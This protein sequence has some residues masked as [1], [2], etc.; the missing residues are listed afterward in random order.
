LTHALQSAGTDL[1][2]RDQ[3]A[4]TGTVAHAAAAGSGSKEPTMQ[5]ARRFGRVLVIP[6][7]LALSLVGA[8]S[9]AAAEPNGAASRSAAVV[10][11]T[12]TL[13]A[14]GAGVARLG[15]TYVL[16]GAMKGGS[17]TIV[18]A[19]PATSVRVT[20]W[21][22][23]TRLADG[24]LIYRGVRG[25]FRIAGRTLRTTIASPAMRFVATGHGTAVLRGTGQ[26][27]VNGRGPHS[28]SSHPPQTA[29]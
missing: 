8:S 3:P 29:F 19:G 7:V 11:G 18:G 14:R 27:W 22:S 21:T 24:T 13:A 17:I 9:V 16:A 10:T 26:Y 1:T 15:G 25:S 6:A 2:V 12:G 28:W 4:S 20:G 23:K 5:S